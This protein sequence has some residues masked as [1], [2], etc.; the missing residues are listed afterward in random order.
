MSEAFEQIGQ[1]LRSLYSLAYHSSNR[2]RDA[3]FHKVVITT[4]DASFKVRSRTGYYAR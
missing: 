2:V 1:E 4:T 3:A